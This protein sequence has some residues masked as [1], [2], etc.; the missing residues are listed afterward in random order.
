MSVIACSCVCFAQC[1]AQDCVHDNSVFS[2][3]FFGD[4][5]VVREGVSKFM[6]QAFMRVVKLCAQNNAQVNMIIVVYFM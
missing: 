4:G 1:T 3:D 2:C 6:G 5:F